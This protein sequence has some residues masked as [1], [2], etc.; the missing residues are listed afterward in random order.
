MTVAP[1]QN[2][3]CGVGG[4]TLIMKIDGKKVYALPILHVSFSNKDLETDNYYF[5]DDY[6]DDD[7]DD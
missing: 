4:W 6:D 2:D 1:T 7:D 3:T 5:D